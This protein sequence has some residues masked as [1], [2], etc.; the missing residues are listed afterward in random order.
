MAK[1]YLG[2]VGIAVRDLDTSATFYT[3][4]LGMVELQRFDVSYMKE[5]VLGFAGVRGASVLLM[6]YTDGRNVE[7]TGDPFK[8]VFYVADVRAALEAARAANYV[9]ERE[10]AEV[11]SMENMIIGF[12]KDPD[13]CLIELMQKPAKNE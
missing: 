7:S 9:V 6:Q 8:L 1:N 12:V 11:P 2:A 5:I 13:G 10:A 4:I 3:T